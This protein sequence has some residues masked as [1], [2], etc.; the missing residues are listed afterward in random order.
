M[1]DRDD[2]SYSSTHTDYERDTDTRFA[3][4]NLGWPWLLALLLV[5]LILA[6]LLAGLRGGK[7]ETN[8]HDRS[9]AALQGAGMS[10]VKVDF[11]G[12][13]ATLKA[14]RGAAGLTAADLDKAKGIVE[15]V[16]GVRV[17]DVDTAGL[18]AGGTRTGAATTEPSES[19][20]GSPT[21]AAAGCTPATLQ[22]KIAKV[23]GKD[24]I[25]FAVGKTDPD[26]ASMA[27]LAKVAKLLAPCTDVTIEVKGHTDGFSP[28]KVQKEKSQ[29]RAD[30]VVKLLQDGGVTEGIT[31]T[32]VGS[33]EPVGDPLGPDRA[34]NRFADITVQ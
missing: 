16:D 34:L 31:G 3:Y 30:A 21:R 25:T 12:R 13:D 33:S 20:T 18:K 14:A 10:G 8:L 9:L 2:A 27:E 15:G 17:A 5:P 7:I 22:K 23:V 4:R 19:S 32:G 24:N 26:A 29:A 28:K 1:V 6:A 11:D